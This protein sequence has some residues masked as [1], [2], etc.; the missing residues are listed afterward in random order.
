[1]RRARPEE[2]NEDA[3]LIALLRLSKARFEELFPVVMS[4]TDPLSAAE[5]SIGGLVQLDSGPYVVVYG[6]ASGEAEVSLP[7]SAPMPRQW[8]AFLREVPLAAREIVWTS[9]RIKPR[10]TAGPSPRRPETK[11]KASVLKRSKPSSH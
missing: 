9:D 2:L 10:H 11:L 7:V 1:M 3:K 5:P 4:D 6:K 8:K